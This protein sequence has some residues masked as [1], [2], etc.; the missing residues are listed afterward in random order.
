[1][2]KLL[3]IL[4]ILPLL[5]FTQTYFI[6]NVNFKIIDE[7]VY[8]EISPRKAFGDQK[9]KSL[10]DLEKRFNDRYIGDKLILTDSSLINNNHYNYY[11]IYKPYIKI[12][13]DEIKNNKLYYY[14]FEVYI[15][16]LSTIKNF[17][18]CYTTEY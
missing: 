7:D 4:I 16:Q 15:N 10:N 9:A 8:V 13:Y 5:G 12:D 1:M 3:N 17:L 18:E 2:I 14:N 6:D 11:L